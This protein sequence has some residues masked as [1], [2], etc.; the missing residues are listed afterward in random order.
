MNKLTTLA[1]SS[2]IIVSCGGDSSDE[3]S[4]TS[5]LTGKFL[6]SAVNNI[7]YKTQ[8][9]QGKTN[10]NGEFEYLRNERITFSIGDLE[11]PTIT[12]NKIITPLNLAK[13]SSTTDPAVINIIRLLQSLDKNNNP[14]GGIEITETAKQSAAPVNF[15]Q[16]TSTFETEAALINLV[17]NGG[18]DS[19][20]GL[21]DINTAVSHLNTTIQNLST[22]Y[23]IEVFD[24]TYSSG[25]TSVSICRDR[26]GIGKTVGGHELLLTTIT[27]NG[28]EFYSCSLNGVTETTGLIGNPGNEVSCIAQITPP[29]NKIAISYFFENTE[30]GTVKGQEL[31][32]QDDGTLSGLWVVN[33]PSNV[34]GGTT[35]CGTATG[36]KK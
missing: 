11:F 3:D 34:G 36:I 20:N 8:T 32:F 24:M 31:F 4:D 7:D 13:S 2:L 30:F 15:F 28:D 19:N 6:D 9:K 12:A 1:F 17:S 5:V 14:E 23:K 21:V 33:L 25:H 35:D 27:V 29:T 22:T 26:A 18:Q 10:A 16:D